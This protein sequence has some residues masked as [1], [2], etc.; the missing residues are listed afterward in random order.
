MADGTLIEPMAVWEGRIEIAGV[1]VHGAFEVFD[2][3][4]N[5][6]FL[7]GKPLLKA[8]KAV[9][10]YTSD[11]VTIGNKELSATLHN[12]INTGLVENIPENQGVL[13]AQNQISHDNGKTSPEEEFKE[14]HNNEEQP[15]NVAF[16]ETPYPQQTSEEQ[17]EDTPPTKI[18]VDALKNNN[19]LFTRFTNPFKKERVDEILRQVKIGPDLISS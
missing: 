2:S 16:I 8:F 11:T 13:G 3:G 14:A 15:T 4:G 19:N 10:D 5:W 1:I 18:D 7:F 9:H 6:D 12:K 17:Q